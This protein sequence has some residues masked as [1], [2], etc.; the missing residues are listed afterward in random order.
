M[1]SKITE[2]TTDIIIRFENAINK[3][4][5]NMHF[6]D[7]IKYML[8]DFIKFC[9]QKFGST[10]KP[11]KY[12]KSHQNSLEIKETL[13]KLKADFEPN[14]EETSEKKLIH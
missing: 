7:Q 13:T 14:S 3:T 12:S 11:F 10:F 4:P 1:D 6:K 5:D 9:N 2:T 8:N